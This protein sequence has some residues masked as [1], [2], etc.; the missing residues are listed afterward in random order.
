M[1]TRSKSN[2][3]GKN[4]EVKRSIIVIRKKE[5][6]NSKMNIGQALDAVRVL[7]QR[8]EKSFSVFNFEVENA[9]AALEKSAE[10]LFINFLCSTKL[11]KK[12]VVNVIEKKF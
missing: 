10:P 9:L 3:K 6:K 4:K 7:R 11:D 8:D 1:I 12:F 5:N 2:N